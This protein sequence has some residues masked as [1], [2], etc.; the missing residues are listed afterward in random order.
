MY[1]FPKPIWTIIPE[2][3]IGVKIGT[4]VPVIVFGLV[5]N[6]VLMYI[7]IRNRSLQTP[8]NLLVANMAVADLATLTIS[9]ILFMFNN[10]YQIYMLGMFGCKS[11]AFLE[12]KL[13]NG[14]NL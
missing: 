2:W 6:L 8:T 9:P 14:F 7:I 1:D 11:Q 13:S 12:G 3:E 5:S 4:I 10:F